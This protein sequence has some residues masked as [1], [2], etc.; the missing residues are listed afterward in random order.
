MSIGEK[1]TNEL[2]LIRLNLLRSKGWRYLRYLHLRDFIF[3]F[4]ENIVTVCSCGSGLGFAELAV[5]LEFPDIEFLITDVVFPPGRPNYFKAMDL[6][7]RWNIKNIRFGVWDLLQ[8]SCRQYDAVVSTEVLEHIQN[9]NIA[10]QHMLGAS[11]YSTYI[12]V[13]YADAKTNANAESR[14][15]AYLKHEHFVCG[16]DEEYF[17]G[18]N[19]KNVDVFGTYWHDRGCVLRERIASMPNEDIDK[20]FDDI[21]SMANDDITTTPPEKGKCAGVKAIFKK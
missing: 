4:R 2:R 10:M 6:V 21:L 20:Y 13:P 14:L 1:R 9:A 19:N 12:L 5:A 17:R 8:P 18:F 3:R 15:D 11:I 16:F 7:M